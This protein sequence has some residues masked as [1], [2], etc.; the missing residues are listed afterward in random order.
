MAVR[1]TAK[2]AESGQ[3]VRTKA[4]LALKSETELLGQDVALRELVLNVLKEGLPDIKVD[5]SIISGE[6]N[7]TIRG[8]S[9]VTVTVHDQGRHIV[10]AE[11]LRAP[12]GSLRAVDIQI[13]GLYYRLTKLQKQ[14]D[15]VVLVFEDRW[16]SYLRSLRGPRKASRATITRAGF[17]LQLIR[18]IKP[19][20]IPV[21]IHPS[22]LKKQPIAKLTES[23]RSGTSTSSSTRNQEADSD[24]RSGFDPNIT[25]VGG[26]KGGQLD[27]V[28][29]SMR[30]AE[31]LGVSERVKLVMLV[32]GLGESEWRK[33]AVEQVYGTHKG[34]FQSN[35]IPP[36]DLEAQT[37]HFLQG[38][39]S[40]HR[41]GAIGL[42]RK[43]KDWTIGRIAT[44]T[45]ISDGSAEYY[46]SFLPRARKILEA[47]SGSSGG[48]GDGGTEVPDTY[49]KRYE[50]RVEKDQTYWDAI[51]K[52]A[53]EVNRVAFFSGGILHYLSEADLYGSRARFVLKEGAPGVDN[54]DFDWDYRKKVLKARASVRIDR[55]QVPPGTIVVLEDMG[56]A[57]GRW[58]VESVTRSLFSSDA[59]LE[60]VQPRREKLEPRSEKATRN[61]TDGDG[62]ATD[63]Y[64]SETQDV[65]AGKVTGDTKGLI[66]DMIQL[67]EMVSGMTSEDIHVGTG[68]SGHDKY[69]RDGNV[70]AH[71]VGRGVDLNVGGDA[72]SSVAARRKGDNIVIAFFRV[73]G[74]SYAEAKKM[75]GTGRTNF[76]IDTEWKTYRVEVGW[77]TLVGGDHYD[78]VHF[79]LSPNSRR[80]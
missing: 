79:G 21:K 57:S 11:S 40:F 46:Q 37:R 12:K 77:L 42:T 55:W 58:L 54:I 73:A 6:V 44:E 19:G 49:A 31:D 4:K 26:L 56:P 66:P 32:A 74:F 64:D 29:V 47:W 67:L 60:L 5:G 39:R 51:Q 10:R 65:K 41:D 28:S 78:H 7:R 27:N 68:R 17:I 62:D 25:S 48:G 72:R 70:S 14:G 16:V 23:E 61:S 53:E 76:S 18:S 50:F 2:I 13:D 3:G 52:L 8:A 59:T 80:T 9:E 36:Q 38:G 43:H 63:E 69:T 30:I 15:D 45:E 22:E 35:Q 33:T 75:I 20:K 1:T 34:V 24:R 71:S